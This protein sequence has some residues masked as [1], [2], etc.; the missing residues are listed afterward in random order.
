MC[1]PTAVAGNTPWSASYF[2]EGSQ[3]NFSPSFFCLHFCWFCGN[4]SILKM[5]QFAV[6]ICKA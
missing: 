2:M 1:K 4:I 6:P 5:A 3:P